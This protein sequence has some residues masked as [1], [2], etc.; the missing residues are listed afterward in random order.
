MSMQQVHHMS[1]NEWDKAQQQIPR[2]GGEDP[3]EK[4]TR[5]VYDRAISDNSKTYGR[6][7]PLQIQHHER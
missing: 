4:L 6:E 2:V 1:Q 3:T 5:D 7:M